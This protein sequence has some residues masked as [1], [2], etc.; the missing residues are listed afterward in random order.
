MPTVL[1][2]KG[3]F[4]HNGLPEKRPNNKEGRGPGEEHQPHI[5]RVQAVGSLCA[6][7]PPLGKTLC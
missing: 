3:I 2:P 5:P 1:I 4:P 7:T 6:N